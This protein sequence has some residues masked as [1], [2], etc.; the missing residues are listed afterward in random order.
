ML[1][2]VGLEVSDLPRSARFY[3]AVL[4]A[5]GHRRLHATASAVAY[6][7]VEPRLW[8][9]SR[10]ED[11]RPGYGHVALSAAGKAPGRGGHPGGPGHRR[12]RRRPPR[13]RPPHPGRGGAGGP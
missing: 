4:Y 13:A 11:A 7:T 8:I 2:H 3:D 5:L 12:A 10:G 9:V 6:G 1:D